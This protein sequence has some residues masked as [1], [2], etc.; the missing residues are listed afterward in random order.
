MPSPR[1]TKAR[2]RVSSA[3]HRS[4]ILLLLALL[5][6]ANGVA[7]AQ[8][9]PPIVIDPSAPS[10]YWLAGGGPS[11]SPPTPA[12]GL[13]DLPSGNIGWFEFA[14]TSAQAGWRRLALEG[15]SHLGGVELELDPAALPSPDG[16]A[17]SGSLRPGDWVWLDPGPH[18]L[19]IIQNIWVGMPKV[20]SI[21]LEAPDAG[22]S[23]PFRLIRG[24]GRTAAAL[25]RCAPIEI[26]AGG[27]G[28]ASTLE[29]VF[30]IDGQFLDAREVA[31]PPA[32]RPVLLDIDAPCSR[33]GDVTAN[34]SGAGG[35]VSSRDIHYAVFDT[36]RVEPEFRR[37][38]LVREIDATTQDPEFGAGSTA[39]VHG[40]A[41]LYR[42]TSDRGTQ[43]YN[44][45][46][47]KGEEPGWFAYRLSGLTRGKPY[48]LEVEYP[49]DAVR[50]FVVA[51]RDAEEPSYPTSIGAETGAIWPVSN[52]MAHMEAVFWP[53][54]SDARVLVLNSH[55][56]MKAAISR[57]RIFAL[58]VADRSPSEQRAGRDVVAWYEEGD[59]FRSLVGLARDRESVHAAVDRY[60][61]LARS[62]GATR[63]SPS[64]IVYASELYPSKFNLTFNDQRSDQAAAFF[65]GAE[66]YGMTVAPEMHPRAD[67]LLWPARDR[68]ALDRRLLLSAEG[69]S[70]LLASDGS[71]RRPPYY[72]AL[73]PDVRRWYLGMISE[74]AERYRDY[75][76]F[77]GI[78]LRLSNWQ[79][80]A[81]N[82]LVSL[83]WGYDAATVRRFF[84]ETGT[85][86][87]AALDLESDAAA[88]AHRRAAV[89]LAEL[90]PAWI[91]WRC[92]KIRDV[93]RD[94]V[95]AVRAVRPDLKVYVFLFALAH[96]GQPSPDELREAGVDVDLLKGI[97]GLILVDG[98]FLHG[99]RESDVQWRRDNRSAF[100]KPGI[101]DALA[102]PSDRPHTLFPAQYIEIPGS[103]SPSS[104]L[105]WPAQ[106]RS[107]WISSV[108]EPPGRLKLARYAELVGMFDVAMLGD[109][110]N[111]YVFSGEGLKDFMTEFRA[112]PPERFER[113]ADIPAPII[114]RECGDLFYVVNLSPDTISA[115]LVLDRPGRIARLTTG[116]EVPVVDRVLTID[117]A[118][119][120][121]LTF[122]SIKSSRLVG[123]DVDYDSPR[124]NPVGPHQ[125]CNER[126]DDRP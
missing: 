27:G 52:T 105:G 97:D 30:R 7:N 86:R 110:G 54:S 99:A 73:D 81:L 77:A 8:D 29:V 48:L 26:E 78:Q 93:Y 122:R 69:G 39:V 89:L 107:P 91:K 90:R 4:L 37:G 121:L 79:N 10:D 76:S 42:E 58:D 14:F 119:Y 19:R 46:G 53:A 65:L 6:F 56:G 50:A 101:L 68:A 32:D 60:L 102:K 116:A 16:A 20:S 33:A 38:E 87:P 71:T 57:I 12:H 9:V 72:N 36:R 98:R 126:K 125:P 2:Y 22:Q 123:A 114:V 118:P 120:E 25:G 96:D 83:D 111:G 70:N 67:K 124:T 51:L 49:D 103:V 24:A 109:G 61:R 15:G 113:V 3:H 13:V 18:R 59:D 85:L 112:L 106:K 64:V 88:A 28:A 94:I 115:R 41:G 21:R 47:G 108:L 5:L 34:V 95:E 92:E 100:E 55:D 80:P 75:P 63:V 104:R 62:M 43:Q 23:G 117:M 82:N 40:G 74:F 66:P 35:R 1:R 44:R 17:V 31:V 84:D 11:L 45:R